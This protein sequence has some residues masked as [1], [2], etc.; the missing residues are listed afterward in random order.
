MAAASDVLAQD[1][2]LPAL[3]EDLDLKSPGPVLWTVFPGSVSQSASS[4]R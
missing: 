4:T 2:D 1:D 3:E